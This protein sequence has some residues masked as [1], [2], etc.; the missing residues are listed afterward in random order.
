MTPALR[1]RG[2]LCFAAAGY[3]SKEYSPPRWEQQRHL[4]GTGVFLVVFAVESLFYQKLLFLH[5]TSATLHVYQFSS[6]YIN[7]QKNFS[8]Y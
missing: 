3:R 7:K 5:R 4:Q 1:E 8:S 6:K 2:A